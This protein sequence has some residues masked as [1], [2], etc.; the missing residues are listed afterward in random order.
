VYFYG[1]TP[2]YK[3]NKIASKNRMVVAN[4]V[5]TTPKRKRDNL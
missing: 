2:I 3:N 1:K 5:A 4:V